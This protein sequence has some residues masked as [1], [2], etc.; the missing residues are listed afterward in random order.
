MNTITK[1]LAGKVALVTGGSRSIG[2]AIAKRLAADGAAVALTYNASPDKAN[3]VV[4]SIEA[5][6]GKALAIK[7][8]A[9]DTEA[10][11]LTV[12]KT[13]GTFGAIDILVNNAGTGIF[14]PIEQFSLEDFEKLIAINVRGLF[15]ATQEAPGESRSQLHHRREPACRWRFRSLKLGIRKREP[16]TVKHLFT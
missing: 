11:R 14:A 4:R 8:A 12:A 9:A 5:A 13:I 16:S 10:V 1:K 2:A 15:V 7:A 3:E 6:G